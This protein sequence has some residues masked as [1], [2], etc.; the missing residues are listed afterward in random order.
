MSIPVECYDF[1]DSVSE[2]SDNSVPISPFVRNHDAGFPAVI[3][4]FSGDT[5]PSSTPETIGPRLVRWQAT[6]LARTLAEAETYG[7]AIVAA[8]RTDQPGGCPQRVT[9]VQRDYE[10]AYDAAR[11]GIYLHTT[12]LEFFA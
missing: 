11:Q 8:A 6:V 1:L 4:S 2:L 9:N 5:F 12:D 7:E 10:P 3:F